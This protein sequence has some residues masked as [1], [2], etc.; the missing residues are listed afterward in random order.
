MT[1]A[2]G[3]EDALYAAGGTPAG[4]VHGSTEVVSS[5][6]GGNGT[7]A[8]EQ[9]AGVVAYLGW[10][11]A[12]MSTRVITTLRALAGGSYTLTPT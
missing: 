8:W 5:V 10:S 11:G 2:G 1:S 9:S 4:M 3:F 7:L 6:Q 12:E